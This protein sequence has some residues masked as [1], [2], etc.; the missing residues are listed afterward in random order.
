MMPTDLTPPKAFPVIPRNT[1]NTYFDFG[2][3]EPPTLPGAIKPLDFSEWIQRQFPQFFTQ[4]GAVW[5]AKGTKKGSPVPAPGNPESEGGSATG[6]GMS[7]N[8]GL[9]QPLID[10]LTPSPAQKRDFAVY[11][12]ALIV[13]VIAIAAILR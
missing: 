7:L 12:L 10:F 11:G 9:F 8:A 3:M 6:P 13:F 2:A 1:G 5:G 4:P